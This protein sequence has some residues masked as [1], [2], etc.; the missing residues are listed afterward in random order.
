M[1]LYTIATGE[2]GSVI[3]RCIGSMVH[4]YYVARLQFSEDSINQ[5]DRVDFICNSGQTYSG[6]EK[7]MGDANIQ[8]I[9]EATYYNYQRNI[10]IPSVE[11][12]YNEKQD[13]ILTEM[14]QRGR[15]LSQSA[16]NM[17]SMY[18]DKEADKTL[19]TIM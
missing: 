14:K 11:E 15:D 4:V 19:M 16:V 1:R 10:I 6:I 12:V 7:F 8:F 18:L 5:V 9:S 13:V 17:E 2:R 3:Y